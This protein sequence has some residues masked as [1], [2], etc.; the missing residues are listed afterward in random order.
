VGRASG[1]IE[2][3][4]KGNT[5]FSFRFTPEGGSPIKVETTIIVPHWGSDE[6]FNRRTL[7]IVYLN[8][9]ARSPSNEAVDIQILSGDNAG[10]RD[11][12]DARP[13][14]I[15]L[16]IPIGVALAAFGSFGLR[17]REDDTKAAED[18]DFEP[19]ISSS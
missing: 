5:R 7:R 17:Y 13:F 2:D 9:A 4:V 15:W 16:A 1:W 3:G 11:S 12:L 18:D 10:W 14:G 8:H 19:G 6:I